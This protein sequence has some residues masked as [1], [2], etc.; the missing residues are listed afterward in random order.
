MGL[1]AGPARVGAS[2][3]PWALG[4]G[5]NVQE[6]LFGAGTGGDTTAVGRADWGGRR[7]SRKETLKG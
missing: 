4:L 3:D 6:P 7:D 2:T 1:G 5:S